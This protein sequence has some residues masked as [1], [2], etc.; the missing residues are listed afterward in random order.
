MAFW[1]GWVKVSC[2]WL[3]GL[4][5]WRIGWVLGMCVTL[6]TRWERSFFVFVSRSPGGAGRMQATGIDLGN[7]D[8]FWWR[9]GPET[10][11][12]PFRAPPP[13]PWGVGSLAN[14]GEPP[15]RVGG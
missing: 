1:Q 15:T 14:L 5:L 3:L 12:P 4:G 11:P 2:K 6:K 7:R 13:H 9:P 10:S 8:W